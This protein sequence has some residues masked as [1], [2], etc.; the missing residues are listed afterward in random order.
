M[1]RSA[2]AEA[3]VFFRHEA[4]T[5]ISLVFVLS[6]ILMPLLSLV[7][8]GKNPESVRAQ[9]ILSILRELHTGGLCRRYAGKLDLCYPKQPFNRT[10]SCSPT[11]PW[12]GS[13]LSFRALAFVY[14]ACFMHFQAISIPSPV[15]CHYF[16]TSRDITGYGQ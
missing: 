11:I 14:L 5:V 4:A 12:C 2:C 9:F 1:E 3:L 6:S 13:A 16:H 8:P 7:L 15:T 10:L